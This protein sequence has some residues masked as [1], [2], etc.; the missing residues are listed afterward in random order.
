MYNPYFNPPGQ[1]QESQPDPFAKIKT[2]AKAPA[3]GEYSKALAS[4]TC[5]ARVEK[6]YVPAIAIDYS[7]SDNFAIRAASVVGGRPRIRRRVRQ[8]S[9][10]IAE[11]EEGLV[12][13]SVGDGLGSFPYS[14]IAASLA[15][16]AVC[17]KL[18][19]SVTS[20]NGDLSALLV[21]DVFTPINDLLYNCRDSLSADFATTLVAAV[22][23]AGNSTEPKVWLGRVGDSTAATLSQTP[24][25]TPLWQFVF[26]GEDASQGGVA[27]TKT[28]AMPYQPLKCEQKLLAPSP[29][30]AALFLLTDG[31]SIPLELGESVRE[32]LG[33]RW[34]DAPSPLDFASHLGFNRRGE[35]DDR[36]GVGV[37]LQKNRGNVLKAYA[38]SEL[39]PQDPDTFV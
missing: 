4:L 13:I 30:T 28:R 39:L 29:D 2:I 3:F 32:G 23:L 22:I 25:G 34:L 20:V 6:G 31:L 35:L 16:Q 21:E 17:S 37:W 27:T 18:A 14:H 12:I 5:S 11:P 19:D 8:D 36:T 1:T 15:C 24:E 10:A 26:G 7:D 38:I 9:F 33:R